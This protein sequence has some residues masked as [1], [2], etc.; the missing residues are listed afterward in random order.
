MSGR[1]KIKTQHA[2]WRSFWLTLLCS[3]Q[4]TQGTVAGPL[5][6]EDGDWPA[7]VCVEK[8]N[9]LKRGP[10]KKSSPHFTFSIWR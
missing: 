6:S 3:A 5:V 1:D 8:K 4:C 9:R 2:G 7:D 10:I